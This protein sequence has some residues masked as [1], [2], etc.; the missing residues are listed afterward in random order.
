MSVDWQRVKDL[1]NEAVELPPEERDAFLGAACAGN[2]A[3]RR[4]VDA[5][6][7][8]DEEAGGFL[9]E[10]EEGTGTT[11]T[12]AAADIATEPGGRH[13][14]ISSGKLRFCPRCSGRFS[15]ADIVCP[16]D[17]EVLVEDPEA[18]V[19]TTIDG[20][21]HVTRMIGRGGFGVVYLARHALLRD[22]VAIKVLPRQLSSDP[23]RI[24]RFLREG[25]AARAISHPNLVT[26]YD[27]RASRD[28][29][30]YM[31]QEYVEGHTL[32]DE[33]ELR[34]KFAPGDALT[35]L[36]PIAEA[37]DEAHAHG[38]VHRDMKPDNIMLSVSGA[39][40]TAKLLDL[41]IV[42]LQ[43]ILSEP[44]GTDHNVT[45]PG[46]FIGTPSY[47]S[48]EQWGTPQE[49]GGP[50]IDGRADVYSFGVVM[51]EMLSGRQ[52]F[53]G[54]SMSEI[55]RAHLID[56]PPLLSESDPAIS[57]AFSETL[58][59]AMAKVR[60]ERPATAGAFIAELRAALEETE[61]RVSPAQAA[62]SSLPTHEI[63]P[64]E[65][66]P[67]G[68]GSSSAA[69]GAERRWHA[70]RSVA[71]AVGIAAVLGVAGYGAWRF[72]QPVMQE[73]ARPAAAA[74][75]GELITNT[76]NA[77][78]AAISPD[79]TRVATVM[80]VGSQYQLSV[81][82]LPT[83]GTMPLGEP[84][85]A[86]L[87]GL[88]FSPDGNYVYFVEEPEIGESV[89]SKIS[90]GG[91]SAQR[92][93]SGIESAVA[94]SPGADELAYVR[95]GL[96]PGA[97]E[98]A[99]ASIDGARSRA[100]ATTTGTQLFAPEGPSWSPDG[101]RIACSIMDFSTGFKGFVGVVTV[102]DGIMSPLTKPDWFYV[103]RVA[104]SSNGERVLASAAREPLAAMQLW[105]IAYPGG[106][107]EPIRADLNSNDGVG[108]SA[109][110]TLLVTVRTS[111]PTSVWLRSLYGDG[112][113]RQ[114]PLGTT[115]FFGVSWTPNGRILFS[116]AARGTA[117][118][119]IADADGGNARQ[120]TFEASIDRDPVMSRDGRFVFFASNRT[121]SFNIWRV[122]SDGS[123]SRQITFG[124]DDEFPSC[125][126]D[127]DF[128][129]YQGYAD[130]LPRLWRVGFD[131]GAPVVLGTAPAKWPVLSPDGKWIACTVLD[132]ATQSWKAAIVPASGNGEVR[133]FDVPMLS[134]PRFEWQRVRWSDDGRAITYLADENVSTVLYSLNVAD[135]KRTVVATFHGD[136]VLSYDVREGS[137]LCARAPITSDIVLIHDF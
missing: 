41:G 42:K 12:A 114:L 107:V 32:R 90:I 49:D 116:S 21:Y 29:L 99:I 103:G 119:W 109:D 74:A 75:A 3:L 22:F 127:G 122:N 76:G 132:A 71:A 53:R 19:D 106:T 57:R 104:W 55:R 44:S 70:V 14:A 133:S 117:D 98:L 131:G 2:D 81:V 59:R 65:V 15:T 8:A 34:G 93:L 135:G 33:L 113:E 60:G 83:R 52:P 17:G 84:T 46:H 43:E 24:E 102:S 63:P 58:A 115:R 110:G 87:Y 16:V 77:V 36:E 108:V 56:P 10:P 92:V 100:V 30:T 9:P 125:S 96:Q 101:S 69:S 40:R 11:A 97:R 123:D 134:V 105:E 118:V 45:H 94:I 47:M 13:E 95:S 88:T 73:P 64:T 120:L 37:L 68:V 129:V 78:D 1:F 51:F 18:L 6:L 4:E 28:G 80:R 5:L 26:V 112:D 79:G 61:R 67:S 128:L 48:P 25:R 89:L 27:L 82:H 136:S 31:V 72:A 35:L 137:L 126:A 66:A 86:R 91:G 124:Q 62:V 38:I 50:D 7:E 130:L 121:G 111:L 54:R 23:E 20:L 85:D 39:K